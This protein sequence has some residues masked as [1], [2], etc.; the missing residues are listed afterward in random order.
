MSKYSASK[1]EDGYFTV[2]RTGSFKT[3]HRESSVAAGGGLMMGQGLG[4]VNINNNGMNNQVS[5]VPS[6]DSAR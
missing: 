6:G 2:D 5:C 1:E 3:H 4:M